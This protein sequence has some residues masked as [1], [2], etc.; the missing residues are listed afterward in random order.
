MKQFIVVSYD[1]PDDRRRT[2]VTKTLK[3]FGQHVQYSVFECRLESKDLLELRRR[4]IRLVIREDS[5]RFYFIGQEDIQ[6]IEV[7]GHGGIVAERIFII[8]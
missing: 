5:V 8:H 7:L 3:G 6:R 2:K 1:I 4:L